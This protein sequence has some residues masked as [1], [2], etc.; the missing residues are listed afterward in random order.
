MQ[1]QLVLKLHAEDAGVEPADIADS[2]RTVAQYLDEALIVPS[3]NGIVN[4]T[5]TRVGYWE[6]VD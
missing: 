2:L 6:V 3:S 5:G 4:S 1:F